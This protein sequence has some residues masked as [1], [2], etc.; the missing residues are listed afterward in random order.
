MHK[1]GEGEE[2]PLTSSTPSTS[3]PNRNQNERT[4]LAAGI[5][6]TS[7]TSSPSASTSATQSTS[8][9]HSFT[10]REDDGVNPVAMKNSTFKKKDQWEEL[11]Q[12][13]S[14]LLEK[15]DFFKRQEA[16]IRERL[17]H[18]EGM[19]RD[20]EARLKYQDDFLEH[21]MNT[22]REVE[23]LLANPPEEIDIQSIKQHIAQIQAD[24]GNVK[25]HTAQLKNEQMQNQESIQLHQ[26]QLLSIQHQLTANFLEIQEIE[27]QIKVIYESSK[28]SP[29]A[30][31]S[32]LPTSQNE[33]PQLWKENA[34][35]EQ[36][37]H[38]AKHFIK[39][40]DDELKEKHV[41]W[42]VNNTQ[43]YNKLIL[44]E[45]RL[46]H[47]L[48]SQE[49]GNR[50][51]LESA[52]KAVQENIE[53]IKQTISPYQKN[54]ER[55]L[56]KKESLLNIINQANQKLN[57]N[58][59]KLEAKQQQN[60]KIIEEKIKKFIH[61]HNQK[62]HLMKANGAKE[63]QIQKR[64]D[65]IDELIT[66]KEKQLKKGKDP[67]I[68]KE[69]QELDKERGTLVEA[70][71]QF[72]DDLVEI[73]E[74][75]KGLKKEI[76]QEVSR[77]CGIESAIAIDDFSIIDD[78][79]QL[80]FKLQVMNNKIV[81]VI[82]YAKKIHSFFALHQEQIL[83][84]FFPN[85]QNPD[86]FKAHFKIAGEETHN[87]GESTVEVTFSSDLEKLGTIFFKPRTAEVESRLLEMFGELNQESPNKPLLAQYKIRMYKEQG[88]SPWHGS[89][90]WEC[91]K[92]RRLITEGDLITHIMTLSDVNRRN[93]VRA[94][95]ERL[96]RV[97]REIGLTDLH[98]ENIFLNDGQLIP[99]DMEVIRLNHPTGLGD[100]IAEAEVTDRE[101]SIIRKYNLLMPNLPSRY[102]PLDTI[103]L[104][105][106]MARRDGY[107]GILD[108]F[109]EQLG[110]E[111]TIVIDKSEWT[112]A[113][114][115]DILHGD[116]PVC[117]K[118]NGNVFYGKRGL[119]I[120][121][122]K[123]LPLDKS[124]KKEDDDE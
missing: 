76:E 118:K 105:E 88:E 69:V 22:L 107:I 104:K 47:L 53:K 82:E 101:L 98:Q 8:S 49:S 83:R 95:A 43:E 32:E 2:T 12:Q 30:K 63:E 58:M 102:L 97:S 86:R 80:R 99:V 117:Y 114:K 72:T 42:N 78:V 75:I 115:E 6:G 122:E 57:E 123:S 110:V 92:G 109:V 36:E 20:F 96:Q 103:V 40:I 27:N 67:E 41:F 90:V 9:T 14:Q 59:K 4:T 3:R 91:V 84:D 17:H 51:E 24:I 31:K 48:N 62:I 111:H 5:I 21:K 18:L 29:P 81:N 121:R 45:A 74:Q 61:L 25:N 1:L 87:R 71:E 7:N 28:T 10:R 116:V 55:L 70:M 65:V 33:L 38:L 54:V 73:K 35:M 119:L 44:E 108:A 85:I 77:Q 16:G 37:I 106:N 94:N 100:R 19:S 66:K 26:S 68:T 15:Q 79:E 120:A 112:N 56:K 23:Q 52:K 89:S 34:Q 93:E 39:E 124:D 11:H 13:R 46:T 113:I 64:L 50:N 60:Q